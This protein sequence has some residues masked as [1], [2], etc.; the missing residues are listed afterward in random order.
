M[1]SIWFIIALEKAAESI[2]LSVFFFSGGREYILLQF[3]RRVDR[4]ET[5]DYDEEEEE[6]EEKVIEYD[7]DDFIESDDM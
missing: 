7:I 3:Q 5:R 1:N 4:L 6:E 2:T